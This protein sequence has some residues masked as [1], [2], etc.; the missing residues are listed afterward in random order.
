LVSDR[1][2]PS[3]EQPVALYGGK[4]IG[5]VL[6]GMLAESASSAAHFSMPMSAIDLGKDGIVRST[7]RPERRSPLPS[8]RPNLAMHPR[9]NGG[10]RS[11][12]RQ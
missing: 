3:A 8:S 4:A 12:D 7:A 10:S 1:C 11:I 9:A 2:C 6:S 5:I